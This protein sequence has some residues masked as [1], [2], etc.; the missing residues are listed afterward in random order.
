LRR[1]EPQAQEVQLAQRALP[2]LVRERRP[3][4]REP[5]AVQLLLARRTEQQVQA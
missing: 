4:M 3:T 1:R 5:Q 2:Q